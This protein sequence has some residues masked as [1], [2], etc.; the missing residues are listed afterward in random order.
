LGRLSSKVSL[1]SEINLTAFDASFT[2]VLT[3]PLTNKIVTRYA[4]PIRDP[5]A[6]RF[7]LGLGPYAGNFA[8]MVWSQDDASYELKRHQQLGKPDHDRPKI[9][10]IVWQSDLKRKK[11]RR[12]AKLTKGEDYSE[13]RIRKAKTQLGRYLAELGHLEPVL[14][15]RY[16]DGVLTISVERGPKTQVIVE[17]A[18]LDDDELKTIYRLIDSGGQDPSLRLRLWFWRKAIRSGYRSADVL[19][20]REAET[21]RVKVLKDD[22][23]GD[24]QIDFGPANSLLAPLVRDPKDRMERVK[25]QIISPQSLRGLARGYLAGQGYVNPN[26]DKA[27]WVSSDRLVLPIEPGPKAYLVDLPCRCEMALDPSIVEDFVGQPFSHAL[28]TQLQRVLAEAYPD[29]QRIVLSPEQRGDDVV[30]ALT[31]ISIPEPVYERLT[32]KG[33]QRVDASKVERFMN[34]EPGMTQSELNRSHENLIKAGTYRSVRL[35][36]QDSSANLELTERNRWDLD[37]GV[38]LNEDSEINLLTQF[39][40]R[41]LLSGFND[42]KARAEWNKREK[43]LSTQ[44]LFRRI[45]GTPLNFYTLAGWKDTTYDPDPE[46]T[47]GLGFL[48]RRFVFP[49]EQRLV[50]EFRYPFLRHHEL[51]LGAS[52][53]R[54]L[55]HEVIKRH[56]DFDLEPGEPLDDMFVFETL[57]STNT[58]DLVPIE[59]SWVYKRLDHSTSPRNGILTS[60]SVQQFLDAFGSGETTKGTRLSLTYTQFHSWGDWLWAQR[61]KAGSFRPVIRLPPLEQEQDPLLFFLGGPTTL[62]GYRQDSVGPYS[63]T[64]QRWI[65]G[66]SM[67]FFSHELSYTTPWFGILVTPFVDGG[68]VWQFYDDYD[69][70]DLLYSAGLGVGWNGPL[71]LLQVDWAYR[72]NEPEDLV[73]TNDPRQDWY[74]RIGRTF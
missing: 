74:F 69:L 64:S 62:R 24:V 15:H 21:Y 45:L 73:L 6:Q 3:Q 60:F 41:M 53:R 10:K 32:I 63:T 40:D 7:E 26:L 55:F 34:F 51:K 61:Y 25:D 36:G 66:E 13:A 52:F 22:P 67:F 9:K 1:E 57:E 27:E 65:G 12:H 28:L 47:P 8:T 30:V 18:T 37:Y 23:L 54:T 14:E 16:E 56:D 70:G 33:D 17:G 4:V 20:D 38:E 68:Q 42:F 29:F 11:L 50:A 44:S 19:V 5:N 35:F 2:V 46:D 43:I 48:E 72:L 31:V 59:L 39:Q 49:E 58:I 71:G